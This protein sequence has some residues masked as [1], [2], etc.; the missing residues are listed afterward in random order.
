MKILVIGGCGYTGNLL[1]NKL[2]DFNHKVV[3]VDTQWFGNHL[4][5]SQKLKIIKQ[6]I[7]KIDEKIFIGV[8]TIVH[9]ANIAND[10][11]VELNPN[12]SWEVNVVALNKIIEFSIKIKLNILYM[13]VQEVFMV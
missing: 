12:L 9:L 11:S 3:V 10:P 6:D 4:K 8:K 13:L 5:K 7:R 1:V 2:L